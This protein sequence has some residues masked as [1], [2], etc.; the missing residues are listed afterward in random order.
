[1]SMIKKMRKGTAE[2][3]KSLGTPKREKGNCDPASKVRRLPRRK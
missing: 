2:G 3:P 1:M